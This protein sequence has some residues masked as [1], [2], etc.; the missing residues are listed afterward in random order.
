M[1]LPATSSEGANNIAERLRQKVKGNP[2]SSN[3]R[4]IEVSISIGI[5]TSPA[6]AKSKEG[7]IEKADK[8]LYHAKHSGRDRCVVWSDIS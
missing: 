4:L 2:F 1:I 6:D 8:A 5:A 7:L 3:G